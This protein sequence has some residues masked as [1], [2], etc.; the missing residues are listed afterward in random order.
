MPNERDQLIAD[1][2][3]AG[4]TGITEEDQWLRA[5]FD[6]GA[7]VAALQRQFADYRPSYDRQEDYDWVQHSRAMWQPFAVGERFWLVPEWLDDAAPDNRM[8]LPMP[9]ACVRQR[10]ASGDAPMS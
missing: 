3:E 5:F 2:W 4:T 1:L 10:M 9:W 6:E 7:D 8:R